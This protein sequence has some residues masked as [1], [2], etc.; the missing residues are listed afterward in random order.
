MT[1]RMTIAILALNEARNLPRCLDHVPAGYPIVLV[2]SGSTDGTAD[3]ARARGA[4]IYN[5][6]WPGF[7]AQRNFALERCDIATEW[8][9]FVDADE[10]YPPAFYDWFERW[11]AGPDG[12]AHD[13]A[14]VASILV[15]KG[16]RLLHAPG[17]PIYHPRL[18]RTAGVRFFTNHTGHGESVPETARI[19]HVDIPYDHHFY[20]GDLKTWMRKHIHLGALEIEPRPTA[21][22]AMTARGRLSV[23]LGGSV[24]RIPLRFFYHYLF[25]GG[26][27]DGRAGFEY[28]LMY[29]WFEGTKYVL[30][31]AGGNDP[32]PRP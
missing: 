31:R 15:F 21:G 6:P 28:A 25:K 26:F 10:L 24:L 32:P 13:A 30:R 7:A 23:A 5:N 20:D 1:A 29:A 14:M 19:A 16:V 11:A 22:T 18:V 3:I 8:T 2:D 27:R 4:R 9:L 12:A 17:Y